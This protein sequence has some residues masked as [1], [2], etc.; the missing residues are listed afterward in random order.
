MVTVAVSVWVGVSVE[1]CVTIGD[2]VGVGVAVGIE[3]FP[4]E[5]VQRDV[6]NM[7]AIR[8]ASFPGLVIKTV[9][10]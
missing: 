10:T 8:S 6:S 4:V 2:A 7:Y 3:Q 5:T 9:P 1:V